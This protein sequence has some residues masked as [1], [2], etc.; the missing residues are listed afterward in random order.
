VL[1]ACGWNSDKRTLADLRNVEPDLTEVRIENGLDRA[2]VGYRKFLEEAPPSSRT[3][4]AMRRLADLE[5]ERQYGLLSEG[6]PPTLAAPERNTLEHDSRPQTLSSAPRSGAISEP[7]ESDRAFEQRAT[8]APALTGSGEEVDLVLPG[9]KEVGTAG[10]LEAI[11]L[12]DE[13]LAAYPNYPFRD[14]ILYQKARAYDELGRSD[15]AIAVIERLIVE[16]P[17]SR[18]ID[19]VQFRRAEYFFVRR[20]YFDAENSYKSIVSRGSQSEY[21]EL[22]LY[23]LGWTLYKLQFHE[24]ALHQYIALLDFKVST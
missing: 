4:E 11:R 12:Y 20:K 3:P 6:P 16:Y 8:L 15:E 14:Q 1:T 21:Y 10:P 9:R 2:I 24:E 19:E 13:I 17:E 22:A 23:K 5:L 7:S 18:H